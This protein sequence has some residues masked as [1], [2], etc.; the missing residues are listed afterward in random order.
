MSDLADL[1]KGFESHWIDAPQGKIFARSGGAGSPVI[2]LHGFPQTHVMWHKVAPALAK[3]HKVIA[4]DLRGY[5]WSSAPRP[6]AANRIYSKRGMGEDVLAVLDHF[7]LVQAAV[8]GH[9]RGGRVAYR[10]ALDHPGRVTKL[11]VVDIVPTHAMWDLIEAPGSTVARHWLSLSRPAKI[12]EA[13]V[14]ANPDALI[15]TTMA[16]WTATGDLKSFDARALA[17]YRAFV[18]D[19][20]RIAAMCADYRAGALVD[21]QDDLADLAA[22]KKIN[23]PVMAIWGQTGIPAA[24]PDPLSLWKGLAPKATGKAIKGGHF[25]PEENAADVL[26]AIET[27]LA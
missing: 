23:I 26:A 17:H 27:F 18:Q 7:G 22:G 14:K 21:R 5:G 12:A 24:S 15:S 25:L 9:D 8:V 3:K 19:P 2:L 16:S 1:F 6:D 10:F 13:D 4:F 11:G 20:S